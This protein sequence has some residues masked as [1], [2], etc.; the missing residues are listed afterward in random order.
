MSSVTL[1]RWLLKPF[2]FFSILFL[3]KSLLAWGV[4]FDDLQFW[5]SILTELP[6]VWA[7]FFLIERFASRRKLGYYMTVNLL[8][9]AIF[10][11]RLCT[12][13]ITGLLSLTM[14]QSR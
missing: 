1:K 9:T 12:S 10:L 6:F 4:I 13:S 8:V 11:P 7:L 14:P 2:V 5:K 3:F